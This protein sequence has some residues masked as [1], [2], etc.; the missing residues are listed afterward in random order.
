MPPL[1]AHRRG[2]PAFKNFIGHPLII[3][4]DSWLAQVL[5]GKAEHAA[6]RYYLDEVWTQHQ[7]FVGILHPTS[8]EV[9]GDLAWGLV[10]AGYSPDGVIE[11]FASPDPRRIYVAVQFHPEY[12]RALAWASSLFSY[13]VEG[14]TRDAGIERSHYESFRQDILAWL[15][16][17]A[18]ALHQL[19]TTG[20]DARLASAHEL[21][22]IVRETDELHSTERVSIPAHAR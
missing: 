17:C 2:R 9:L 15:W 16:Q 5:R 18:R 4:Q 12:Q 19:K 21:S 7:N 3:V 6:L 11:A 14:A 8:M 1:L 20:R 10:V 13:I 22:G